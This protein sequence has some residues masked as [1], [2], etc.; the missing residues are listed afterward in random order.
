[1]INLFY[2]ASFKAFANWSG[3]DVG[4]GPHLIPS[5]KEITSLTGLSL[6]KIATPWV[7][8]GQPPT[9][10]TDLIIPSSTSKIIS[11]EHVPAVLY[12]YCC[13]KF[14]PYKYNIN[15]KN[16]TGGFFS[17]SGAVTATNIIPTIDETSDSEY[18][19]DEEK[20]EMDDSFDEEIPTDEELEKISN[21]DLEGDEI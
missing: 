4:R 3:Q 18:I 9:N 21:G 8:P 13:I 7:F 5:N 12:V 11:L 1:M 17:I 15:I 19:P 14:T 2:N 20:D 16:S 10:L 6:H